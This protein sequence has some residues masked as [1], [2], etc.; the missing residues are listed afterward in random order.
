MIHPQAG[1]A[2]Q[3]DPDRLEER[4]DRDFMK[5]SKDK[6]KVLPQE[7]RAPGHSTGWGQA[8]FAEKRASA[9]FPQKNI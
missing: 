8:G 5:F 9:C 4:A 6:H 3:R 7:R 2:I 1:T